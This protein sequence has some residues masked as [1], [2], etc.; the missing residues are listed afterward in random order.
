[1]IQSIKQLEQLQEK[2]MGENVKCQTVRAVKD[3]NHIILFLGPS[4]I[5]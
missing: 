4:H 3:F 5:T 1:M 2:E